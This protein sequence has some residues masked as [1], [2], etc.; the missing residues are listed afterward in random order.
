MVPGGPVFVEDL[1]VVLYAN[2]CL[3]QTF[4]STD[5]TLKRPKHYKIP[6]PVELAS[7]RAVINEFRKDNLDNYY[8]YASKDGEHFKTL[9]VVSLP[10]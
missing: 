6:N 10:P 5:I 1:S 3:D 8:F 9:Q 4:L 7:V 2:C